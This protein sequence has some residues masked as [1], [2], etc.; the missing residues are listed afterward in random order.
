M[1]NFELSTNNLEYTSTN[2]TFTIYAL[3][4]VH[5]LVN[6]FMYWKEASVHDIYGENFVRS[7]NLF[8]LAGEVKLT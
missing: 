5:Y 3:P 8:V 6:D 7:P 4:S 2:H 1:Y